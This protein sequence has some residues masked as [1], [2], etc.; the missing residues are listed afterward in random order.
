[1]AG[2]HATDLP[3]KTS[4]LSRKS[5]RIG[6]GI[7]RRLGRGPRHEPT[8]GPQAS[9]RPNGDE[10]DP[11]RDEPAGGEHAGDPL[12]T[13]ASETPIDLQPDEDPPGDG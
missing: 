3:E 8:L 2:E 5:P 11:L 13:T 12:F 6:G 1:M 9:R 4:A 7:T 10:D